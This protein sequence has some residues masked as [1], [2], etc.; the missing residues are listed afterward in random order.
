MKVFIGAGHGGSDPGA[1][2]GGFYEKNL[3][4][5]VALACRE[6]L[7]RHGV[8]VAMSRTADTDE[9]LSGKI[10]CCNDFAPDLALDIHHNAGGGD[11]AEVYHSFLGGTGKTLAENIL[12]QVQV[13][14]QNSRGAKTRKNDR[15]TDYFAFIRQTACPAVIVE[16]AFLDTPADLALVNTPAGQKAM[17]IAIAKGI[18]KTLGIAWKASTLYRVQLGAYAV[19]ANAENQLRKAKAAG[20]A[21]A[22]ITEAEA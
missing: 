8:Q 4:L 9:S 14:G 1:C 5:S 18:L 6:E 16:C 3:N 12:T 13:I 15:G 2:A 19:R 10:A 17:G 20:F 7:Q 22:F 21:D 11:G